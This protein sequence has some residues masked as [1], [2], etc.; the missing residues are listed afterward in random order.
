MYD[1]V[2]FVQGPVEMALVFL[3]PVMTEA[4]RMTKHHN[5]LRICFKDFLKKSVADNFCEVDLRTLAN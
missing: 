5:K 3:S 4:E 1:V 2:H